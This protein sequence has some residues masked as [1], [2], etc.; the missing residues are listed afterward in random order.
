[1]AFVLLVSAVS[2]I[3]RL[4]LVLLLGRLDD[5]GVIVLETLLY[6]ALSPLVVRLFSGA[7]LLSV[8]A[9]VGPESSFRGIYRILAYAWG[10]TILFW[11]PIL[12]ALAFAYATLILPAVGIRYVYRAPFLTAVVAAV[13]GYVPSVTLLVLFVFPIIFFTGLG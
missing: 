3:L 6:V 13:A 5:A 2:S 8:R 11:V 10:A 4:L 1:M 12:G 9:L 7:Y